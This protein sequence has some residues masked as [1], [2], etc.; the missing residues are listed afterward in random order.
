MTNGWGYFTLLRDSDTVLKPSRLFG[1]VL[2]V[3]FSA[4]L[5]M[6][7]TMKQRAQATAGR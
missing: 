1:G 5:V 2:E 4:K 7:P 3:I 6:I